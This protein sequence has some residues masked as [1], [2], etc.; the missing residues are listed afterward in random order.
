VGR[1]EY[2][3]HGNKKLGKCPDF[4]LQGW[5]SSPRT[6][7]YQGSRSLKH[8]T[9]PAAARHLVDIFGEEM[10]EHQVLKIN[11]QQSLRVVF[12]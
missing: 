10:K 4:V 8:G 9:R 2:K 1:F 6:P 3:S 5:P 7:H 12:Y 11:L